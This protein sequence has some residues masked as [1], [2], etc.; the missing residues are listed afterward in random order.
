MMVMEH[1]SEDP[2]AQS[3]EK[4]MGHFDIKPEN[5]GLSDMNKK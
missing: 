3:W 1:G 4:P 5:S 2:N